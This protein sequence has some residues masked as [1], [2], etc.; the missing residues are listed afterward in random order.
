M[1]HS[2][3]TDNETLMYENNQEMLYHGESHGTKEI[4]KIFGWLTVIT[5][6]DIILYFAM[7]PTMF[8]NVIFIVFGIVKAYLIVGSFM[9]MKHERLNLAL[10]IIVPVLF[11][12]GLI[13]GLLYVG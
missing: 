10:S 8:R 2:A 11:I 4:W 3:H 13:A 1:A 5:V 9:H 6:L 7:Q 12:L